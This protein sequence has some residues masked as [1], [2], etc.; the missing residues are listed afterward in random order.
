MFSKVVTL[1]LIG[2]ASAQSQ[3]QCENELYNARVSVNAPN[4][5]AF[6]LNVF[7]NFYTSASAFMAKQGMTLTN[8]ASES[9]SVISEE[10]CYYGEVEGG[11][12]ELEDGKIGKASIAFRLLASDDSL[13]ATICKCDSA[14]V[15][16]KLQEKLQ[17]RLS[18]V[19][20]MLEGSLPGPKIPGK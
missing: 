5:K 13:T 9:H 7:N 17:M 8:Y 2:F 10:P 19:K 12:Y 18:F 6:S 14:D 1:C 4:V 16:E 20:I 15:C 3:C 11:E